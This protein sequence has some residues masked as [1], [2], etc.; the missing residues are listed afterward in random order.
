VPVQ[1]RVSVSPDSAFHLSDT[2]DYG[3]WTYSEGDYEIAVRLITDAVEAAD[4]SAEPIVFSQ[5]D[6]VYV[7]H[8]GADLQGDITGDSSYD[9]PSFTAGLAD[10]IPVDGG[11]SYVYAATVLP[12]TVSQDNLT[13]AIN[14]VTA[15]ETGPLG[16]DLSNTDDFLPSVGCWSLM[17]TGNYCRDTCWIATQ[18]YVYVFGLPGGLARTAGES[19]AGCSTSRRWKRSP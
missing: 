13:G 7:Y 14:G 8:A 6:M 15:H 19:W 16:P 11:A 9:I 3:P 17:D 1:W 12:E 18:E 4:L 2:A 10:P 5:Y